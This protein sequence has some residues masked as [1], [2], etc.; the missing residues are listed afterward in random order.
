M[1][2]WSCSHTL[3]RTARRFLSLH[4]TE[5]LWNTIQYTASHCNKLNTLQHATSHC[6]TLQHL[7]HL[8]TPCNTLQHSATNCKFATLSFC[9]H[10]LSTMLQTL[11]THFFLFFFLGVWIPN[12]ITGLTCL[13]RWCAKIGFGSNE[14]AYSVESSLQ[15]ISSNSFLWKREN[16]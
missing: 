14:R 13:S 12:L 15:R 8:T 6:I 9:L 16:W 10:F 2:N 4:H 11:Y 7:H 3:Q 1:T 5:T